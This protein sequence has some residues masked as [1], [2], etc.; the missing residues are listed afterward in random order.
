MICIRCE[1]A[2]MLVECRYSSFEYQYH[3]FAGGLSLTGRICLDI[4]AR[5]RRGGWFR[6]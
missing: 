1:T 3:S 2:S 5:E 6:W 4:L